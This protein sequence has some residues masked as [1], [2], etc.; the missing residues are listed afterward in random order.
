MAVSS[1]NAASFLLNSR[2][3]WSAHRAFGTNARHVGYCWPRKEIIFSL[4]KTP[5][6]AN[7]KSA[8]RDAI[9]RH[10]VHRIVEHPHKRPIEQL[11]MDD[12]YR[13]IDYKCRPRVRWSDRGGHIKETDHTACGNCLTLMR[14]DTKSANRHIATSTFWPMSEA[15]FLLPPEHDVSGWRMEFKTAWR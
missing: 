1:S 15:S 5:N 6:A 10:S 14:A 4:T 3:Y 12:L 2:T 13:L 7:S 11:D 8:L 9:K